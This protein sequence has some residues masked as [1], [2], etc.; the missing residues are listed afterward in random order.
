MQAPRAIQKPAV[1][2]LAVA[3]LALTPSGGL[4]ADSVRRSD[5]ETAGE[6]RLLEWDLH[7]TYELSKSRTNSSAKAPLKSFITK[8]FGTG[9]F[10]PKAF[11]SESFYAPEFLLPETKFRARASVPLASVT[12]DT[13]RLPRP[14]P[15]EKFPAPPNPA[16][17]EGARGTST[18]RPFGGGG[19]AFLG[20]EA[21]RKQQRYNPENAPR[22]GIIE[23]RRLTVEDVREILNKSK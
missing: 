9:S 3:A 6:K 8:I 12:P 17:P 21:E 20:P 5:A 1:R 13:F 11:P 18:P 22:G 10:T 23:G 16:L 4:R 2:L 19:R 15:V 7:K 14:F